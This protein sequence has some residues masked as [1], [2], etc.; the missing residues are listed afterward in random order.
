[1]TSIVN[2]MEHIISDVVHVNVDNV[3]ELAHATRAVK[4]EEVEPEHFTCTSFVLQAATGINVGGAASRTDIAQILAEDLRRKD[5]GILPIDAPIV[6]CTTYQQAAR[7]SNQATGVPYPDGAYVPAL[8][9]VSV[10]G[11]GPLWAV[12]TTPATPCR[13]SV[14]INR[15][16]QA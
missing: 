9:N 8:G 10:T 12:N 13:V 14:I 15:R 6:L 5:A 16:G 2:E 4:T 1:M 3:D 7:V 11:T